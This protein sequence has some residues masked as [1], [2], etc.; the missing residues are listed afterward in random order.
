MH[1]GSSFASDAF[2]SL[3]KACVTSIRNR[4]IR[5]V[6]LGRQ[7][8]NRPGGFI[9]AVTH[10]SHLEP[11]L[12]STHLRRRVHWLA[13]TEFFANP[14]AAAFLHAFES[15]PIKRNGVPVLAIRKS[16]SLLSRDRV[17]GIFPEGG[18]AKGAD[19]VL[20][21]GKIKKGAAFLSCRSAR[22]IIPVVVLGTHDLNRVAPWLP[23]RRGRVQTAYGQPLMP[24]AGLHPRLARKELTDRL[25]A[26]YVELYHRLLAE[27]KLRDAD[28]P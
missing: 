25:S 23:Y 13:R 12:V 2:Y 1:R 11:F 21:G 6:L 17:V 28:I 19:S 15:I 22:P 27:A 26:A 14:V 7:Y 9:L 8:L 16:I 24:P 3:S 18:V 4:C 10:L 20:R 5:E